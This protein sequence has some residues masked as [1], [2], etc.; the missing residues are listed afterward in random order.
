[1]KQ[2][3]RSGRCETLPAGVADPREATV[4]EAGDI[5]ATSAVMLVQPGNRSGHWPVMQALPIQAA[6][7]VTRAGEA[8]TLHNMAH[9]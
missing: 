4:L 3:N 7:S 6:E 9:V 8:M 5:Q 1:M 2:G